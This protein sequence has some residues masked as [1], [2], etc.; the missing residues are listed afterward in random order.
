MAW[1]DS[2]SG[3]DAMPIVFA[4]LAQT[5]APTL[6]IETIAAVASI[7]SGF[8]PLAIRINTGYPLTDQP[9][10]KAEAVELA[11]ML[12]EQGQNLDLG[13]GGLNSSELGRL[14]L[15]VSD[16]FEPCLNIKGTATLLNNY[17]QLAINAGAS[18]STAEVAM[19]RSYYGQGDTSTGQMVGYDRRIANEKTR[20]LPKLRSLILREG[21]SQP[22]PTREL[23]VANSETSDTAM[24][25]RAPT[26][27]A[28]NAWVAAKPAAQQWDVFNPGRKSSVLVFSNQ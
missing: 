21:K 27:S 2:A 25:R 22:L 5:C 3:F 20:L 26:A 17:Y 23:T 28:G 14:G 6:P 10:T 16:A 9:Q 7:E 8:S 4:D 1:A 12:V 15:T 11:T 19:L 13:L 24:P 18:A